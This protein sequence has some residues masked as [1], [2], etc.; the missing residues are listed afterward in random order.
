MHPLS[1]KA[2]V[3]RVRAEPKTIRTADVNASATLP[4][5][6]RWCDKLCVLFESRHAWWTYSHFL[7]GMLQ[8]FIIW[9]HM[10]LPTTTNP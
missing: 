3:A 7:E 6:C 2:K 10:P 9:W 5:Y 1:T 8:M 4:W